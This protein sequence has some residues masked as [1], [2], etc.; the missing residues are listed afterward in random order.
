LTC[1][2]DIDASESSAPGNELSAEVDVQNTE[3]HK[4]IIKARNEYY[5]S[6]KTRFEQSVKGI[7]ARFDDLRKEELRFNN[8]W[9]QNLKEIT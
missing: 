2:K 4:H 9:A 7:V 3:H 1:Q 6:F 8:Y 5:S